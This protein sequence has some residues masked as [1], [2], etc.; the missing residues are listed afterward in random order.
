MTLLLEKASPHW[1]VGVTHAIGHTSAAADEKIEFI[2]YLSNM[3]KEGQ[4]HLFTI[5]WGGGKVQKSIVG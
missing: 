5:N 3:L 1:E 2:T 4:N